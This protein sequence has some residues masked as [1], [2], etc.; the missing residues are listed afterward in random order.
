MCE[1]SAWSRR[2]CGGDRQGGALSC[3]RRFV[4]HDG[5]R[6]GCR[7]RRGRGIRTPRRLTSATVFLGGGRST[8]AMTAGLRLAGYRER[9]VVYDRH[10]EKLRTLRRE[11]QV[12]VAR[13][14][15]SALLRAETMI[16]AVRPD[17]VAEILD[18]I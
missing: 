16:V 14:L 2:H 4:L 10:A 8:S 11:S 18:E 1:P 17:S 5:H 3:I 6:S 9:V 12:E 13:D 15:K 7:W